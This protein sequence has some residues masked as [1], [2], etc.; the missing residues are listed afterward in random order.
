MP[1][2]PRRGARGA[3]PGPS[4]TR[5]V[6]SDRSARRWAVRRM[7]TASKI[8]D[9]TTTSVVGSETSEVAPPIT[10]ATASAPAGSAISSVSASSSR[11]TWS[12]VSR[13]SP[14]AAR[15]TMIVARPSEPAWTAAASNVW[16]GL[17][18]SSMT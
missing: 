12:S 7:L 15:R 10:P 13:R 4:R 2:G 1:C 3:A 16:I 14:G 9:S 11:S 18:S 17:P 6:A 5:L 8:A